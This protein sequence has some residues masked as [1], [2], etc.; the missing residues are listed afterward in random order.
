MTLLTKG[1]KRIKKVPL[2][3][4]NSGKFNISSSHLTLR[5]EFMKCGEI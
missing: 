2:M 1:K 5:H 4:N 3:E